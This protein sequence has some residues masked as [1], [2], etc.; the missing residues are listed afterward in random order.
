MEVKMETRL[1]LLW[2]LPNI[3]YQ[4]DIK[5]DFFLSYTYIYFC[6]YICIFVIWFVLYWTFGIETEELR[7]T[8]LDG[9]CNL[10]FTVELSCFSHKNQLHT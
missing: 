6:V 5:N 8:F 10:C 9:S 2:F 7:R 4:H 3:K 1:P